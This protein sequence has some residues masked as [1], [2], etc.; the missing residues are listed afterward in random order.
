MF[1]SKLK[2]RVCATAWPSASTPAEVDDLAPSF[3]S[4][5]DADFDD[6]ESG[7]AHRL[8]DVVF[9]CIRASPLE[10]VVCMLKQSN[11]I[12]FYR[13]SQGHDALILAA[14]L[15]RLDVARH[16]VRALGADPATS[17][18]ADGAN[19]LHWAIISGATDVA[20]WFMEECAANPMAAD[21]LGN[22]ACH[23][24]ACCGRVELLRYCAEERCADLCATNHTGRDVRWW[25]RE[26]EQDHVTRWLE[27][28]AAAT[29]LFAHSHGGVGFE[30]HLHHHDSDASTGTAE[31]SA[32][33]SAE[34]EEGDLLSEHSDSDS[35]Y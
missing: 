2:Q 17:V 4:T 7:V 6:L 21:Q 29:G 23:Y 13:N 20:K 26:K 27:H 25:A 22:N 28:H 16:L 35:D 32:E 15:R 24:A 14:R 12:A 19:A 5:T 31:N 33:E 11:G 30:R 34:E 8:D 9:E 1:A 3:T 10:D 18:G